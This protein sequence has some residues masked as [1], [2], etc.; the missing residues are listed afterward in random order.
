M[1][2]RLRLCKTPTEDEKIYFILSNKGRID[3]L[4]K[5]KAP[6]EKGLFESFGVAYDIAFSRLVQTEGALKSAIPRRGTA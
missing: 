2:I 5:N 6:I 4:S 3:W 1:R